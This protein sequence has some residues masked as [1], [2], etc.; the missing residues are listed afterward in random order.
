M[1][2]SDLHKNKF[3]HV[4][5][6]NKECFKFQASAINSCREIFNENLLR[7]DRQTQRQMGKTLNLSHLELGYKIYRWNLLLGHHILS[8]KMQQL[9]ISI[10]FLGQNIT[11]ITKMENEWWLKAKSRL[12]YTPTNKVWWPYATKY[13]RFDKKNCYS[14]LINI[15]SR[16]PWPWCEDMKIWGCLH[17]NITKCSIVVLKKIFEH[18][19]LHMY[20]SLC[21]ILNFYWGQVS[22]WESRFA[23]WKICTI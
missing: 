1:L 5:Y 6:Q 13:E 17:I 18:F 11:K 4:S 23:Q 12:W 9:T 21:L 8:S 20:M 16:S 3:H 7:T 10:I 22:A 14:I 19:S 15:K 2:T